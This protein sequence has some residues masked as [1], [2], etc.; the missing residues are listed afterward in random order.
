M[1]YKYVC[2]T[3]KGAQRVE[4]SYQDHQRLFPCL[5]QSI[6]I[7]YEYYLF[8]NRIEIHRYDSAIV[9]ALETMVIPLNLIMIGLGNL[10]E[11]KSHYRRVYNQ[12]K[13]GAFYTDMYFKDQ[14][15]DFNEVVNAAIKEAECL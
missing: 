9:M 13:Y 5:K 14:F 8:D 1:A 6:L 12:Q 3:T 15:D 10:S 7:D 4:F 11:F 2:P